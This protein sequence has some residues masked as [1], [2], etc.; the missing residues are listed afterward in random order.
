[1]TP[2]TFFVL[3]EILTAFLRLQF[4]G[5]RFISLCFFIVLLCFPP[6]LV[7]FLFI[8]AEE[9][10]FSVLINVISLATLINGKTSLVSLLLPCVSP[11]R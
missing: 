10:F 6:A 11:S 2:I 3:V 7:V 1:M 4:T 8:L 9:T 5:S